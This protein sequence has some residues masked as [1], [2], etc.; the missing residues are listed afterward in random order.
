V[1]GWAAAAALT[2]VLIF[3]FGAEVYFDRMM[4]RDIGDLVKSLE[5]SGVDTKQV[6]AI[7]IVFLSISTNVGWFVFTVAMLTGFAVAGGLAYLNGRVDGILALNS[8][9]HAPSSPSSQQ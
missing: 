2:L 9:D 4:H 7:R 5:S 8:P 1:G 6:E 3:L